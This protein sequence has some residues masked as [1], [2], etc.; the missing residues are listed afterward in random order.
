MPILLGG[1]GIEATPIKAEAEET[2]VSTTSKPFLPPNRENPPP[3]PTPTFNTYPVILLMW[4][5]TG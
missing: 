3:R 4:S 5:M 1:A 2:D